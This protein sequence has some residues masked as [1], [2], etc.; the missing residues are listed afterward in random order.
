M[1]GKHELQGRYAKVNGLKIYYEIHG[2][3]RPLVLLHGGMGG[4]E[5]FGPNVAAFA[6]KRRVIAVDLE[7]HGRTAEL[8]R[9]LRYE[10]MADDIAGLVAELDLG[11]SDVLGYSLGGGVAL[12]LAIRHPDVVSRLVVVSAPFAHAAFYPEILQ[13]FDRMGPEMGDLMA[14][15]P[16]ASLY[17]GKDW[18][19]L[20]ARVG[21]LLRQDYDW[22]EQVRA[23][24]AQ[25]MLVFADADTYHPEHIVRFWKLLGGG[26]RDAGVDGSL[27]PRH[28]LAVLPDHTHY[29][30][31]TSP[32]LV[33]VVEP[34]LEG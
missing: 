31:G 8:D 23:I 20:F 29:T 1:P 10:R 9:P 5:M 22:S 32:A 13:S 21:E 30:L 6:R 28:R 14:Q 17:P 27:R 12:Q 33:A 2:D 26:Q 19:R 34:F 7:G 25:V 24:R 11:T 18:G 16:L 4:M 3:G 15:S